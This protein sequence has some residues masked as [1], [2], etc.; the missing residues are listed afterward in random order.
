MQVRNRAA[1]AQEGDAPE[2]DG[3]K[4]VGCGHVATVRVLA[5]GVQPRAVPEPRHVDDRQQGQRA[6]I[7]QARIGPLDEPQQSPRARRLVAVQSAGD[8]A[9][10]GAGRDRPS[11]SAGRGARRR[12]GPGSCA[13][14]RGAS[15]V[16]RAW[17]C[18]H[19]SH[20]SGSLHESGAATVADLCSLACA[21]GQRKGRLRI[22][23]RKR[24]RIQ[25]FLTDRPTPRLPTASA[26]HKLDPTPFALKDF[27]CRQCGSVTHWEPTEAAR[28]CGST[29]K[30]SLAGC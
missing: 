1:C 11:A 15:R 13:A 4:L 12:V 26:G 20:C 14:V 23:R 7:E 9:I 3:G 27:R 29:D 30:S 17:P 5:P 18:T 16:H 22:S 8:R 10:A 19:S 24:G 2:R 28:G 21:A 6:G 25:F